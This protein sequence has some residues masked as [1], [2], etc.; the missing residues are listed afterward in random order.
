MPR[1]HIP[2]IAFSF[3]SANEV[4][5]TCWTL[6]CEWGRKQRWI[7][8]ALCLHG[9]HRYLSKREDEGGEHR[10]H[11]LRWELTEPGDGTLVKGAGAVRI[12]CKMSERTGL[13][14]AVNGAQEWGGRHRDGWVSEDTRFS[15]LLPLSNSLF[16]PVR[17]TNE[18]QIRP[19]S[20]RSRAS[21][22]VGWMRGR[23]FSAVKAWLRFRP[24]LR[25]SMASVCE[26]RMRK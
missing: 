3:Q 26:G 10:P 22:E 5:S 13:G 19:I 16:G 24:K 2:T 18:P 11:A 7:R 23:H 17:M 20:Q 14:K 12:G 8:H 21:Q 9:T 6:Y 15:V 25:P 1:R 4:I